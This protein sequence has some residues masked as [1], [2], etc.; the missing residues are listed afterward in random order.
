MDKKDEEQLKNIRKTIKQGIRENK[1]MERQQ[2]QPILE[3]IKG[4]KKKALTPS[5][6]SPPEKNLKTAQDGEDAV[7]K[8]DGP[9]E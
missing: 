6:V 4:I 9:G 3:E 5:R 8:C 1:R 7:L 2:I